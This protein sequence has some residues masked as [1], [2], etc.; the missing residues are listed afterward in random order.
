MIMDLLPELS[1]GA[2]YFHL[3]S[4]IIRCGCDHAD[5]ETFAQVKK[6][7][8]SLKVAIFLSVNESALLKST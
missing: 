5:I 8:V 2:S 4:W 6:K 3:S 7:A 1:M